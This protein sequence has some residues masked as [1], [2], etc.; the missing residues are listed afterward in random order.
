MVRGFMGVNIQTLTPTLAKEFDLKDDSSGVLVSDVTAKSPAEKA[1]I[2][3]GD[4]IV[5]FNG[6]PVRDSRHLKLQVAQTGPG[7]TVPV[8]VL[9]DGKTRTLEVTV[10]ELPG[11]ELADNSQGKHGESTDSLDGVTVGDLDST[12]RERF[13]IPGG[14]RG[15][16]VM[17]VEP[18][19]AAF[20]AGL[21]ERSEEHTSELQSQSNL[22]CRL[23]LEKKK[24]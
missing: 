9:R 17:Q 7:E 18:D 12:A 10:K 16:I 2:K 15:V 13:K 11:T 5:E 14:V 19:C 1:G 4:V 20:E 6:K 24:I 21:R 23:L 8:K 22:V 3:T